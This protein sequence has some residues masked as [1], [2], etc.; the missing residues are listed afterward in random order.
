M[1]IFFDITSFYA[2]KKV[3][4]NIDA[5]FDYAFGHSTNGQKELLEQNLANQDTEIG[6]KLSTG[7]FVALPSCSSSSIQ[8]GNLFPSFI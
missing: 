2:L 1:H 7:L 6:V 4:S 8:T 3:L 5:L